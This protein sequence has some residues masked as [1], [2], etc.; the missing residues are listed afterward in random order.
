[1]N[2][3]HLLFILGMLVLC[4]GSCQKK[5]PQV[6]IHTDMGDILVRLYDETPKHRDNFLKLA[7]EGFY[8]SLLLHRIIR[9]FMI[10]GGDPNSK[11]APPGQLLGAGS[12]GYNIPPEIRA[13]TLRGAL[14]AAR[15][16]DQVNPARESNGS[17]FFIVHGL[18]Q[19]DVSLDEWEQRLGIKFSPERRA[20]YK[21]KG[22][23]PQLDG[24]YTVFGEVV[25]G[26][27]VLD[28]IAAVPRDSN[29]RPLND[30]R[31]WMEVE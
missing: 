6:W 18:P 12:P 4:L 27:D 30:L 5:A 14:A 15:L 1:M 25:K 26:L 11:N 31:M 20:L 22:G 24:Q 8:D 21:E 29:D 7:G 23:A 16:P 2:I 9:D 10:Q 19:T 13:P 28:K 17:Q 3:K